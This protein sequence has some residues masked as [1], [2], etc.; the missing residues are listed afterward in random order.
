MGN[1]SNAPNALL[2]SGDDEQIFAKL[3]TLSAT[4]DVVEKASGRA[5]NLD[6][7]AMVQR[8]DRARRLRIR[9]EAR[10]SK[11]NLAL[12]GL[13]E[14][15][16]QAED[17]DD[18][19]ELVQEQAELLAS[20]GF[21]DRALEVLSTVAPT[22][23]ALSLDDIPRLR[24]LLDKAKILA[25]AG[26]LGEIEALRSRAAQL[27]PR[28]PREAN[29]KAQVMELLAQTIVEV[30]MERVNA[31]RPHIEDYARWKLHAVTPVSKHSAVYH[32]R[33]DDASRGTPIRKGRGGR[34]VWSKLGSAPQCWP[35]WGATRRVRC[36]GSNEITRRSAPLTTG[37]GGFATSSSRCT[38][39]RRARP[40]SGFIASR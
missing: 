2:V 6:D 9:M 13:A 8:L 21:A 39:S 36:L 14:D 17:E 5:P 1:C 26:R 12:A 30:P 10:E 16:A 32:F 15:A 35:R 34:T 23:E 19:A 29:I 28:G 37:N 38:C 4:A 40:P 7:A 25:R 31:T 3:C 22:S 11:W 20:A 18:R 27:P 24:L 33:T